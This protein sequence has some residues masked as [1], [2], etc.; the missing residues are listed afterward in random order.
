MFL[1]QIDDSF[2]PALET[3]SHILGNLNT[4]TPRSLPRV[5][6][7]PLAPLPFRVLT[8]SPLTPQFSSTPRLSPGSC[9]GSPLLAQT[10][11]AHQERE[12]T[13]EHPPVRLTPFRPFARSISAPLRTPLPLSSLRLDS[14][15]A[16]QTTTRPSTP[17]EFANNGFTPPRS[18]VLPESPSPNSIPTTPAQSIT[19]GS[20][21][22]VGAPNVLDVPNLPFSNNTHGIGDELELGTRRRRRDSDVHIPQEAPAAA[23]GFVIRESEVPP[24]VKRIRLFPPDDFAPTNEELKANIAIEYGKI[25]AKRKYHAPKEGTSKPKKGA[26]MG[27]FSDE[28][29]AYM[30]IGRT[31]ITWDQITCSPWSETEKSLVD[32]AIERADAATRLKGE[33]FVDSTFRTTVS[34]VP[35]YL[36]YNSYNYS[37]SVGR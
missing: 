9:T 19:V 4:E 11:V 30:T 37:S 6:Q 22:S 29:Q 26:A 8:A 31:S 27:S 35:M 2:I 14:P 24:Q 18:P 33:L 23:N 1:E 3:E 32:H 25:Q 34:L 7:R 5:E 15:Q 13:T 12:S 36:I 10:L 16:L 17:I 28:Q 21:V 20:G